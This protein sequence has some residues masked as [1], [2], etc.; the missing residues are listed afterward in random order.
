MLQFARS[1]EYF[2]LTLT[3]T[4]SPREREEQAFDC[5]LDDGRWANSGTG[6]IERQ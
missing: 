2:P 5:R 4:L 6:I 3:L 1:T